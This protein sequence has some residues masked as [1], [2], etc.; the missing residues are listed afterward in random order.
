PTISFPAVRASRIKRK[1]SDVPEEKKKKRSPAVRTSPRAQQRASIS[2]EK[3]R[4]LRTF[5]RKRKNIDTIPEV[6]EIK[7]RKSDMRKRQKVDKGKDQ[8]V[9]LHPMPEIHSPVPSGCDSDPSGGR[10]EPRNAAFLQCRVYLDLPTTSKYTCRPWEWGLPLEV[11]Q[12][13]EDNMSVLADDSGLENIDESIFTDNFAT[14]WDPMMRLPVE[15]V[16]SIPADEFGGLGNINESVFTD[17]FAT[18]WDPKPEVRQP[19]EGSISIPI[20]DFDD[21]DSLEEMPMDDIVMVR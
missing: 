4:P 6:E 18:A 17:N 1:K 15:T 19:V 20:D 3:G 12:Q 2:E 7:P 14:A 5:T 13:V 21:L 11:N 10:C 8:I 16:V 9:E